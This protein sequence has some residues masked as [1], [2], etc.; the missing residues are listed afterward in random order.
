MR[1]L[2]V[3]PGSL[4]RALVPALLAAL[5]GA[6]L[7]AGEA[8]PR[9]ADPHF[10]VA[11]QVRSYL[12]EGVKQYR[13]GRYREAA[14]A[15][16]TALALEPDNKDAY[17]FYLA[18]GDALILQM[19]EQ[20]PLAEPLKE[21]L[22]RARIYQK[23]LRRDPAYIR[24]L[25]GKLE[26]SEE[27]QIAAMRE[28]TAVGPW[29][30]PELVW[31][32]T[33]NPQERRRSQCRLVLTRMGARAVLPLT[34]ALSSD[35]QRQ[36]GSVSLI[37]GDIGDPRALPALLRVRL[38]EGLAPVTMQAIDRAIEKIV[39]RA[40]L[41]EVPTLSEA[42]IAEALRYFR[43]GP[44]IR[45]E[46]IAAERLLWRW[47]PQAEGAA[48]LAWTRAPSYAWNELMAEDLL[49]AGM[50]VEPGEAGFLPVLT[51]VYAGELADIVERSLLAQERTLAPASGED[52]LERL[53]A[54]AT[55]LAELQQRLRMS[56]AE[57]LCR[58][59]QQALASE[60]H[61][62]ALVLMRVLAERELVH[63]KPLF[64]AANEPLSPAKP[65]TVLITALEHP[66]KLIRY[67][68]AITLASLDPDAFPGAEKVVPLLAEA[69]GA[70]GMRVVLVVDP[71]PR[72]RNAARAALTSKGFVAITAAD[73]FEAL[74]R[75]ASGPL[76]D[77]IIVAGD[78]K[79]AVKDHN[80]AE[81]DVPQQNAAGLID[82]LGADPRAAGVPIFVALPE[83]PE[84]ADKVR[85][86][87]VARR[88][89][90][91][92]V[93]RP[94][95]AV[96][97]R[98]AIDAALKD[99]P[100]PHAQQ[101]VAEDI[102]LRA[103]LALQQPDPRRTPLDLGGAVAALVETLPARSN[104]I[105]SAA[106]RA[107]ARIAAGPAGEAARAHIARITEIYQAQDAELESDPALRAAFVF[108]IGRIDPTS[109]AAVDILKKAMQHSDAGVRAAASGGFGAAA[110][111]PV[112][113]YAE[114]QEHQRYGIEARTAGAVDE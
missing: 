91:K 11:D 64:P 55:A 68:A 105:R 73:G 12:A 30:V 31:A 25:I 28:L 47:D 110:G 102:A 75:L 59:L 84:Q 56:G 34:A 97:L 40:Q 61:D 93:G 106:L 39:Q 103:A 54:R 87:F 77:A 22:R 48:R 46:M 112:E 45:D 2:R 50:A 79:T 113:L 86:E 99:A 60:R 35:D 10:P 58:A 49:F 108:A 17:E 76:K 100:P 43:G 88:P 27:E 101:A 20:D 3:A 114:F 14:L 65:G 70:W 41:P 63:G 6:P 53:S 96:E 95:D 33:D 21:L 66:D 81:L 36:I 7:A 67:Q 24:I 8:S 38:R 37:L 44:E 82:M 89:A 5:L 92:F 15:F 80:G 62:A 23:Q 90:S 4:S 32:L 42:H 51:A 1:S 18:C 107:L 111:V 26:Q 16:R 19:Q 85:A 94:Y 29:A 74:N 9:R 104:A 13:A 52:A 83:Q 57:N 78:L 71:D 69:L 72:S 98:D 109:R